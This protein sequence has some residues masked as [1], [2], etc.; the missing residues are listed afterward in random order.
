MVDDTT[1]PQ[2]FTIR[3]YGILLDAAKGILV[4]DEQLEGKAFTKFPGGGLHFGEGPRDCLVREWME[5]LGEQV[6]VTAHFY[7]TDFFQRS[8]FNPAVQVI[9]IYYLVKLPENSNTLTT[10]GADLAFAEK[11]SDAALRWIAPDAF[12]ASILSFPIDRIVGAMI[13][14]QLQKTK[15]DRP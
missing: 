13:E 5:E 14:E 9:S 3:V 11:R 2:Q 6:E 15:K 4:A 1:V 8:F 10:S 7:T 12:N